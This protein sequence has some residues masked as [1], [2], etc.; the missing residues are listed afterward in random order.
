MT[1]TECHVR[2]CHEPATLRLRFKNN[3]SFKDRPT[4][5]L[6]YCDEHG[7]KVALG[8]SDKGLRVFIEDI[9]R[10]SRDAD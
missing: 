3:H 5:P 2:K 10:D 9:G 7:N 4:L 8:F 6:D 1:T